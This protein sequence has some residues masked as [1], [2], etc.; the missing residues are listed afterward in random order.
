[1]DALQQ[2]LVEML[3]QTAR[4]LAK[5]GVPARQ[6]EQI[7]QLAEQVDRPCVVAV[8]GRVKAGKSSFINALLGSELAIVGPTETTA[9]INLFRYGSPPVDKP[10]CCYWCNGHVT[11]EGPQFLD[12]LQGYDAETLRCADGIRHLEYRLCH[13]YLEQITLVDTPG[14]GAVVAAHQQRTVG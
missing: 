3:Q 14:I 10:V 7:M 4:R 5:A 6:T 13:P 11:D 1:M 9:T 8:V 2:R 12:R